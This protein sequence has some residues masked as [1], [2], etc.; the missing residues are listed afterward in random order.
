VILGRLSLPDA[1]DLLVSGDQVDKA[2]IA[3][4]RAQELQDRLNGA[5]DAYG[6]G[7]I[8]L[9]ELIRIR[10]SIKPKIEQAQADA[11]VPS[12]AKVLGD[13]VSRDPAEVWASMSDD[14]RRAVVALL[15]DVTILPTRHGRGFDPESVRIEWRTS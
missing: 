11:S 15:V 13:L 7:V 3:A 4:A 10:K 9:T 14:Q 2:R 5:V 6:E 12:R 8:D 1:K